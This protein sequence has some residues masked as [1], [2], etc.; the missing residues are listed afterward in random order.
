MTIGSIKNPRRFKPTGR[1]GGSKKGK[2]QSQWALIFKV[3]ASAIEDRA[4]GS[5]EARLLDRNSGLSLEEFRK[6][7]DDILPGCWD[8]ARDLMPGRDTDLAKL[9]KNRP[10]KGDI[11]SG[12]SDRG[13]AHDP[14][15]RAAVPNE[16]WRRKIPATHP[17]IVQV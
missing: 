12:K 16:S 17:L 9:L 14:A 5:H 4:K 7:M 2:P 3:V 1:G 8:V 13:D 10:Y 11:Y 6:Q 15:T